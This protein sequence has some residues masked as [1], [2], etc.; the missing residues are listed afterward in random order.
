MNNEQAIKERIEYE[1]LLDDCVWQ[2]WDEEGEKPGRSR[3]HAFWN[4]DG[5]CG[6]C[7]TYNK[8][9]DKTKLSPPEKETPQSSKDL[10]PPN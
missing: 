7:G 5:F 8:Y 1:N 10:T 4:N 2:E 6:I 3:T 9:Q